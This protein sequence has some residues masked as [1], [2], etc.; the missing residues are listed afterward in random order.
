MLP[1]SFVVSAYATAPPSGADPTSRAEEATYYSLLHAIP[2]L[3][4]FEV[5]LLAGGVMH[6]IDEPWLLSA[7]SGSSRD[8]R[9]P[10]T[11]VLTT[12]PATMAALGSTPELGLASDVQAGRE[13]AIA[14]VRLARDAVSRINAAAGRRGAVSGVVLVSAPNTRCC[15][16]SADSLTASLVEIAAW[17]WEGAT[18]LV[19]HCD[20]A[21]QGRDPVKGFLPLEDELRAIRATNA[22]AASTTSAEPILPVGVVI[23]WGR[24]VIEARDAA[25]ADAHI[26]AAG[27][28][29]RGLVL[30]GCSGAP[31][32]PAYGAWADSHMPHEAVAAGSLLTVDALRSAVRA[33]AAAAAAGGRPLLYLSAKLGLRPVTAPAASRAAAN[34]ALL[35]ELASAVAAT[36][37]VEG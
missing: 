26:A 30:S 22:A 9:P 4:G 25:A 13:A 8:D 5:P 28:L 24:S 27:P 29:L 18:L 12:V 2:S 37:A 17:D 15:R 31:T 36:V 32:D 34:V 21:V 7:I 3:G 1:A 20:A 35:G 33:A 10:L 14:M 23:N 11:Y 6:G 19:E 16:S